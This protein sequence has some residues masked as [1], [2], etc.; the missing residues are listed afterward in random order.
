MSESKSHSKPRQIRRRRVC[1][2][3]SHF[4]NIV[5][6]KNINFLKRFLTD[7]AKISPRRSSGICAKHQRVIAKSIKRARYMGL[8][9]YAVD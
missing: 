9:P 7:R 3:C 4:I 6:Y 5:D 2:C 1:F 8:L